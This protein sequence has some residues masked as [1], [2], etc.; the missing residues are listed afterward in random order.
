MSEPVFLGLSTA[1]WELINSFAHWFSA[2]ASFVAAGVA[3]YL[4]NRASKPTARALV[5]HRIVVG[6]GSR[7]PYPEYVLFKIVNTGDRPIR[8]SQIGWRWGLLRKRVAVQTYDEGLS[9]RLPID[10]THGQEAQWMV[11]LNLGGQ[12]W[13]DYFA[14]DVLSEHP[15]LS[16]FTLRAEFYLSVGH[17]VR[18]KLES[19]LYD[20]FRVALKKAGRQG[21]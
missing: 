8:V 19:S 17:T 7:E 21:S 6:P 10:L 18:A 5:G 11:P 4:A 12:H 14:G 16:L 1:H 3:L 2:I 15:M 13:I 9:S 20:R